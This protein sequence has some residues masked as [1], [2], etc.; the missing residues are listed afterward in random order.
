LDYQDDRLI[1]FQYESN[2]EKSIWTIAFD[3]TYAYAGT[4]DSGMIIRSKDR[5]I[6]ENF[7]QL[8]DSLVTAMFINGGVLY[9]GTAPNG[10]IY[11]IDL[12]TNEVTL[13]TTLEGPVVGFVIYNNEIYVATHKP[14]IVYKFNPVNNSWITFYDAYGS[15]INQIATF[16]D[17]IF[18]AMDAQNIVSFDG[19]HWNIEVSQPDNIATNRRVSK[20]VFSHVSWDFI[21]TKSISTTEGL[22]NEDILDI[23][24]YNRL[25]GVGSFVQDGT[26]MTIGGSNF[27]RVL[28]YD[29]EK[30]T[31]IF[32]TDTENVQYLLNLDTGANLA[33]MDDKLYLVHCGD[34]SAPEEEEPVEETEDP[35]A[36]KSVIVTSPNGGEVLTIGQEFDI[37]WTSTKG[38]NDAVKIVLYKAGAEV[39]LINDR[40]TNDGIYPWTPPLSLTD[41]TDYQIYIEWL[42]AG[43][44]S[45]LDKD[46]SDTDFSIYFTPPDVVESVSSESIPEGT[47]DL[48]QCRGIPV[49]HFNN[50][51]RIT[52]MTKDVV[53][54]GVLFATS[55][56]RILFAD[57]ATLNAY[58]TGERLIYADVTDG[59]GNTSNITT[60]TFLYALYKRI[61]EINEDKEI[62]KWKYMENT[63]VIPSE[64]VTAVFVSPALQVQEDIGFWK[65]LIWSEEKPDDTKITV[66]VRTGSSV[67]NMQAQPWGVCFRSNDG[68]SNPI[69]R[70]LNNVKLDGQYAQFRVSMETRVNDTTPKV[71]DVN[72]VYSTKRAQYFY[73]VKFALEDQS[74]INK[75][76]LTG[77]I[78]QP[79]NTEVTFGYNS[80]NSSNWDDYT[81]IDPD[82]FF[83]IDDIDNIKI[84]IRMV[85]YDESLPEV[86][87]FGII[88]SGDKI[89]QVN[90]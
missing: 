42:T 43:E 76:L 58:R 44:A 16:S 85:S 24:P 1:P 60:E 59:Y 5:F 38:V 78:T 27:G 22:Q 51:E 39:L 55:F 14:S 9:A 30:L 4:S 7:Y 36:G 31:S 15:S 47:P 82:K 72:L 29:G 66:C 89:N 18:L 37:T 54:G 25:I 35:N 11:R 23:F 69:T 77:T 49:L 17:K 52:F 87:E 28:N 3:S 20:N 6:W 8:D 13:D 57:E 90:R 62:K 86:D 21:D 10:K 70:D 41:G 61:S 84:G 79:T 12:A 33:A 32:E 19:S 2:P 74:D 34:I 73:S 46:L 48:S 75:G 56:G 50:N 71:T 83:D 64:R 80:D 67:R 40:T 65:Q 63:T 26:T 45:D 53:K 68:E 81:I 88:F